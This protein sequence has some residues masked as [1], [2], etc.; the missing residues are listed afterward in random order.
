MKKVELPDLRTVSELSNFM[1][2]QRCA[3]YR[4]ARENNLTPYGLNARAIR[5]DMAE[6]ME[7][8]KSIGAAR[9]PGR[10][11]DIEAAKGIVG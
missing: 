2:I 8:M 5:Y 4:F 10:V 11:A 1:K 9:F 7:A 6:V 3:F